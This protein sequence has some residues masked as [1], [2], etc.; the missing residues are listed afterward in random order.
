MKNVFYFIL[1]SLFFVKIFKFLSWLF[2]HAEKRFDWKYQV[3]FEIYDVT[4]WL[5]GN[6]N[7]YIVQYLK[8]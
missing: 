6:C 2:G 4:T 1:K 8:K 5:T 3:N 7:T